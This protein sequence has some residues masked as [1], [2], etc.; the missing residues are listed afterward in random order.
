MFINQEFNN[1]PYLVTKFEA[2]KEILK[3][4]KSGLNAVIFRLGN[5]MPR[6]SDGVFQENANQNIL[7]IS[8]YT[9]KCD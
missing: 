4:T 7:M 2:E 1:N 5:I 3:A 9:S 8:F 6:V